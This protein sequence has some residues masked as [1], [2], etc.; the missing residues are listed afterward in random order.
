MSPFIFSLSDPATVHIAVIYSPCS[1]AQTPVSAYGPKHDA[2][3]SIHLA[4]TRTQTT[5]ISL[6]NT[7]VAQDQILDPKLYADRFEGDMP[8]CRLR[9]I[10][11]VGR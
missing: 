1:N 5:P 2:H 6:T 7:H 3:P 8:D 10:D 11:Q 4:Q 9:F